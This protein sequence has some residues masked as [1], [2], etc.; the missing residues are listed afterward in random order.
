MT[1]YVSHE[2][3][4]CLASL[5]QIVLTGVITLVASEL[6]FIGNI[7][8]EGNHANGNLTLFNESAT[9]R[10]SFTK[11]LRGLHEAFAERVF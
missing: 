6:N 11:P 9:L 8:F 1:E 2:K 4:P 3:I 7:S 10:E 5:I